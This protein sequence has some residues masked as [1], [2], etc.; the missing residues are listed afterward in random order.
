M[1]KRLGLVVVAIMLISGVVPLLISAEPTREPD[2]RISS[3]MIEDET[4]PEGE[5]SVGDH[6]VVVTV[7]NMLGE[8]KLLTDHPFTMNITWTGNGT[9]YVNIT[10]EFSL[11]LTAG[12]SMNAEMSPVYFPE[13]EFNITVNTTIDGE[14]TM[15]YLD[16]EVMD[17][18][19]LSVTSDFFVEGGT[20]SMGE[21]LNPICSVMYE[22]NIDPWKDDV[23]VHLII[24]TVGT[25]SVTLYEEYESVI[26]MDSAPVSPPHTFANIMFTQPWVIS[27][28][29]DIRAI[30]SVEYETYNELNNVEVTSFNV[31]NPP[32]IEG[33]VNTTVGDPLPGVSVELRDTSNNL[34]E[35]TETNSTG[36]Y[37]FFDLDEGTYTIY[38]IKMWTTEG[39]EEVTVVE[40]ET[41]YANV[42]LQ[43]LNRG[44]LTGKVTDPDG[45]S[46]ENA[47]VLVEKE[48]G[49]QDSINTNETGHYEFQSLESG[50]YTI[51][52]SYTGYEDAIIENAV[53]TAMQWNEYDLVLG[54]IPFIVIF[55][56]PMGEPGFPVGANISMEF[57]REID[58]TTVDQ[59]SIKLTETGGS[60]VPVEY[61]VSADKRSVILDPISLLDYGTNYTIEV[62]SWLK[63]INGN[64]FPGTE[65]SYFVTEELM[66]DVEIEDRFPHRN[67]D[68]VT[69][70]T[71]IFVIFSEPMDATT[72][73]ANTFKLQARGGIDVGGLVEYYS[74]NQTAIFTPFNDLEHG[75]TYNVILEASIQAIDE[76]YVFSGDGWTF[77]TLPEM[78]TGEITGKILDEN[79]QPFQSSM[80][81][82]TIQKGVATIGPE[83]PDTY[84]YYN[85][86]DVAEG[87]WKMTV[88]VDGYE[89]VV[90][91]VS[92]TPGETTTVAEITLTPAE[93][94]P[95]DDDDDGD[96]N[97][98]IYVIIAIIILVVIFIIIV[99]AM[100]KPRSVEA[101]EV[102]RRPRFGRAAGGAG[103]VG[104]GEEY[105]E[106]EFMCPVC[107]GVTESADEICPHCGAEFEE[108][109]FE[110]PECGASLPGDAPECPE[111]GAI[112]E[113]EEPEEE[114]ELYEEEI[115]EDLSE[116]YEL[117]DEEEESPGYYE[118]EEEE[119]EEE[120]IE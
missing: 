107:G 60:S 9:V 36:Y 63:D 17:V 78:N 62:T 101:E 58:E 55:D 119:E 105:F 37:E 39:E 8:L 20:Y 45:L 32:S 42:S 5:Y 115:Q 15:G 28:P 110:C 118:E 68:D 31:Q 13:G 64:D 52:A 30:F 34:I 100:Q 4:G 104:Y 59:F 38:F 21:S 22:G 95:E 67:Q 56:V 25:V 27:T 18:V 89:T 65:I 2:A 19:D 11:A 94:E 70:G 50:V 114:E 83:S 112:F 73:N 49:G 35:I 43:P 29:G 51:T 69:V 90:R 44:G 102:E 66:L 117:V 48:G 7:Q 87:V 106:G 76:R 88:S 91:N 6:V 41:S 61:S 98:W 1:R 16:I 97:F 10:E 47:F 120:E 79:G 116:E 99:F 46:V 113:E 109:I 85:F 40:G 92:V 103:G 33:W 81:D 54:D 80:V 86:L 84:G 74:F 53:I 26:T 75:T 71:N 82:I 108:D 57:S 23:D 93:Q 72:I 111:C 12:S 96:D 14:E 3:V 77:D 24:E